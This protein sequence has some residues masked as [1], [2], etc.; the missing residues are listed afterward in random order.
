MSAVRQDEEELAELRS[1]AS[2]LLERIT[3]LQAKGLT[4]PANAD[5][6]ESVT[7]TLED[8]I[9]VRAWR[10]KRGHRG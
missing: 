9:K 2:R 5:N 10:R 1:L 3:K 6:E 8:H 4:A 7:P